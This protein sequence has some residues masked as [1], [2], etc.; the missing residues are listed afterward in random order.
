ME[1]VRSPLLVLTFLEPNPGRAVA[2]ALEEGLG[3]DG[4]SPT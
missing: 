3:R 4:I 1:G 2:S